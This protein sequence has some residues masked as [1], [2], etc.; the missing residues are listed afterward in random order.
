M[1]E[2]ELEKDSE[3]SVVFIFYSILYLL[4]EYN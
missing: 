1:V 4:Y 3:C 2:D